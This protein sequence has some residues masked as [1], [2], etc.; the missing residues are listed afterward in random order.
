VGFAWTPHLLSALLGTNETVVRG[1]FRIAYDVNY[2]NLQ[3][4]IG[5]SAPF[6]NL[7]TIT[8]STGAAAGLPNVPTLD[9]T[10]IASALFPLAPKGNP[11]FATELQFG[12]NF[13][14]PYSE[15]WNLGIQRQIGTRMA[16]EVRYVGNHGVGNF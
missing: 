3:S 9:G 15:Q 7:A 2:Y 14:N 11:G 6:T 16:A 5:G 4:N 12:K 13:R 8:D 10:S 1:G